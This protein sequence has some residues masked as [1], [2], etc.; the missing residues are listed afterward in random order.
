[1]FVHCRVRVQGGPETC[2]CGH[3]CAA[4]WQVTFKCQP[5]KRSSA[6]LAVP[7]SQQIRTRGKNQDLDLLNVMRV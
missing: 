1:M 3:G 5:T 2:R 4:L 7:G 6:S